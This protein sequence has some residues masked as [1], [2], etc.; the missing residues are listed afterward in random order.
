MTAK[1]SK[2]YSVFGGGAWGTALA[3]LLANKNINILLYTRN[4]NIAEEIN[5]FNSNNTYLK[6]IALNKSLQATAD[7]KNAFQ[8]SKNYVLAIPAQQ[9]R[10]FLNENKAY[11]NSE[12]TLILCAKG[13]EQNTGLFMSQIVQEFLP[14]NKFAILSGPSFAE[15]VTLGLPTA[16]TIGCENIQIAQEIAQDFSSYKFRCYSNSDII[17]VQIGGALKNVFAIACGALAGQGFGES[18]KSALITRC[19]AELRRIGLKLGANIET[20]CGLSGLGDLMLSCNSIKSRNFALG[21]ALSTNTKLESSL[22]EGYYT[23]EIAIKICKD[24]NI[25]APLIQTT[26]DLLYNKN[27]IELIC[28]A[29]LNRP[30]KIED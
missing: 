24:L 30:L 26:Y 14:K 8:Y 11:I 16:V 12:A 20:L 7:L 6:N 27:N 1:N 22:T 3:N 28:K 29:L 4:I 25:D 19:F 15:D 5:K 2:T 9:L 17:G 23:A 21:Y 10:N 13:I 18:A